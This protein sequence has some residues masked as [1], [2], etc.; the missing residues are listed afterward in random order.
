[1]PNIILRGPRSKTLPEAQ[2]S[3]KNVDVR[4]WI[5]VEL[6]GELM[7]MCSLSELTLSPTR[8]EFTGISSNDCKEFLEEMCSSTDTSEN[9]KFNLV[10]D[11]HFDNHT[12]KNVLLAKLY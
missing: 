11:L 12:G 4:D 7:N 5:L 8:V 10:G 1:M 3:S 2:E 9:M 6:Q